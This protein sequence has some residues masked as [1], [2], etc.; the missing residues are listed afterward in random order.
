MIS[1]LAEHPVFAALD[2]EAL[3]LLAFASDR[4]D[5]PAGTRLFVQGAPADGGFL[6]VQGSLELEQTRNGRAV[7]AGTV[8]EGA[9][10]GELALLT[11]TQRPAT[12][13]ARTPVEVVKIP[14]TAFR[15]TLEEY[16]RSAEALRQRLAARVTELTGSLADVRGRLLAGLPDEA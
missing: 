8:P 9:L 11:P 16:P 6:L 10:L 7:S 15:R 4:L 13:V 2:R 1:L 12:A 3:R 14:R 5:Y